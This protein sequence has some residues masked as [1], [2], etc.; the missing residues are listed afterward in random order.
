MTRLKKAIIGM[1]TLVAV[2]ALAVGISYLAT[3]GTG[4]DKISMKDSVSVADAE[5][6][7]YS[8]DY[9][10][11]EEAVN[12]NLSSS[13]SSQKTL[14]LD[15]GYSVNSTITI[16][17]GKYITIDF[18]KCSLRCNSAAAFRVEGT[19]TFVDSN[20]SF[21]KYSAN[22]RD[23]AGTTV[24]GNVIEGV[25]DVQVD[26]DTYQEYLYIAG[27]MF[28]NSRSESEYAEG[29]TVA[30]GG[31]LNMYAGI[32]TNMQMTN[33]GGVCLDGTSSSKAT[34]NMYGGAIIGSIASGNG[35]GVY[36]N[37]ANCNLYGGVIAGNTASKYGGA[38][39]VAGSSTVNMGHSSSVNLGSS[40]FDTMYI[41]LNSGRGTIYTAGSSSVSLYDN[42]DVYRNTCTSS[43]MGMMVYHNSSNPLYVYG[44]SYLYNTGYYGGF[45]INT[46]L[47]MVMSG[48]LV[49]GN[50]CTYSAL[51]GAGIF[52][53]Q[54]ATLS[55]TGGTFSYNTGT[56]GPAVL[57]HLSGS[58]SISGATFTYNEST[59][60]GGCLYFATNSDVTIKNS[61]I[62]YNYTPKSGG[63][64]FMEKV[65]TLT[66]SNVVMEGNKADG[67]G[68]AIYNLGD[69]TLTNSTIKDNCAGTNAGGIYTQNTSLALSDVEI[70]GNTAAT[71]G[72]G[73]YYYSGSLSLSG[74]II[75]TGNTSESEGDSDL[76][77]RSG[78]NVTLGGS[79]SDTSSIGLK[80]A[81]SSQTQIT[82][83]ETTTGRYKTAAPYFFLDSPDTYVDSFIG[84][85]NGAYLEILPV[86]DA[87][88][89]TTD[90]SGKITG[91]YSSLENALSG[92]AS[93]DPDSYGTVVLDG[94][95]EVSSTITVENGTYVA[96]DL[97]GA[98]VTWT[99]SSKSN[100]F[101]VYGSLDLYD[102]EAEGGTLGET[103][104]PG[105]TAM[106]TETGT[107]YRT[108]YGVMDEKGETAYYYYRSG[109]ITGGQANGS[110][111]AARGGGVYVGE[112][113]TFTMYGGTIYGNTSTFGGGVHNYGT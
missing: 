21:K 9:S 53:N 91:Y 89:H 69:M 111:E 110:D 24:I 19:L 46:G 23:I 8:S 55:L 60:N 64:I 14:V 7:V 3:S 57:A 92:A 34:F 104:T 45:Y 75:I 50:A 29:I 93:T 74:E 37:N 5:N 77:L 11:L 25:V 102:S 83:E 15:K 108:V 26:E 62:S 94:D 67:T 54:N 88:A 17:A 51:G 72:G 58:V 81:S 36:A 35:G 47:S 96:L 61:T 101:L 99:G 79:L 109:A 85:K 13:A 71:Y 20:D 12:D 84:F 103:Q 48:G 2:A 65:P 105:V 28:S 90:S 66:I 1:T 112:K 38:V 97:N 68:G 4:S 44:G 31:T 43:T 56:Y 22:T 95:M 33:G 82:T 6:T 27:G 10:S 39:Y 73:I 113:A 63:G 78:M 42:L 106:A 40:I 80:F 49:Y 98:S 18:N 70:R 100:F 107:Q 16:P 86:S 41:G 87:A 30:A 59:G 76:Y 52:L 32:I